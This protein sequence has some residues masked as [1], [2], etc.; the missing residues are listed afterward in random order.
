MTLEVIVVPVTDV[1]RSKD[2]YAGKLGFNVDTDAQLTDDFRVVQ[3]TPPGSGCSIILMTQ[4]AQMEP[5]TLKGRTVR[6]RGHAGR[7]GA[8]SQGCQGRRPPRPS[9]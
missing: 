5:G 2:F 7:R 3:L 8:S 9:R 1:E 6:R 4:G